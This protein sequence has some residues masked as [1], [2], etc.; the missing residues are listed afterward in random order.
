[1][2]IENLEINGQ[3]IRTRMILIGRMK[4]DKYKSVTMILNMWSG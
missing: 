4:A 1:V 3:I 2:K